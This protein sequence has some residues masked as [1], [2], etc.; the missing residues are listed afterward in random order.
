MDRGR[1]C[2]RPGKGEVLGKSAEQHG[3]Q[4]DVVEDVRLLGA[5]EPG[6]GADRVNGAGNAVAAAAPGQRVQCEPFR[7]DCFAMPLHPGGDNDLEP[8]VARRASD[9]QT[10]RAEVPVFGYEKEQFRALSGRRCHVAGASNSQANVLGRALGLPSNRHLFRG[11]LPKRAAQSAGRPRRRH[12]LARILV[13]G[14]AGF[15]G[16]ALCRSLGAQGHDVVGLTR[17]EAA[18]I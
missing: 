8:G 7:A 10:V 6:N 4:R 1:G 15:I 9:R 2:I 16:R 11:F 13:T 12:D 5:I 18:P 3:L 17:T 14:A